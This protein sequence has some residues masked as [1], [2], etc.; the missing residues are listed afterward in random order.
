MKSGQ[1]ERFAPLTGVVFVVLVIVSFILSGDLPDA[2]EETGEVVE[3]W[4]D[5]DTELIVGAL[6]GAIAAL[7][8]LWFAGSLRSALRVA[9]GGTGRLSAVAYGAGLVIVAGVAISAA[10]QFAGADTAGDVPPEVTQT[11]S[12]VSFDFFFPFSVGVAGLLFSSG[13]VALRAGALPGWLAWVLV[14]SVLLYRRQA[15]TAEAAAPPPP[16]AA[17]PPSGT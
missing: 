2:D 1:W 11:I 13:L 7:F 16:R 9:E 3:F 5:N 6:L 14:V 15:T 12:V 4:S 17:P 10:L 8:F